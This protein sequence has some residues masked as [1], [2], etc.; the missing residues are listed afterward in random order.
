MF[1]SIVVAIDGSDA[2]NNALETACGLAKTFGAELH[3]IHSPQVETTSV[4]VGYTVVDL[5]ITPE[6]IK[7]AGQAVIDAATT[8]ISEAG[9][10]VSSTTI[11]DDDPADDVLNTAKLNDADLI[12]MGRRGLGSVASLFLGS[13][14][15]KVSRGAECSCLT[16]HS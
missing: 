2:A 7:A 9:L 3:L 8:K 4:A 5:P 10:T 12:V 16:V 15:Q 6:Q 14:S 11:G 1:T 13:V